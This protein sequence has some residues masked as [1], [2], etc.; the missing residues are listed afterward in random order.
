MTT[1][2]KLDYVPSHKIDGKYA[3]LQ[4]FS[5]DQ[6]ECWLC[7]IRV[8]GN[9][10]NL[11]FLQE[12]LESIEWYAS[13]EW[14]CFDI[15]LDNYVSATTA[16]EMT[17]V[18]LNSQSFHRKF[19][20][21]LKMIDFKFKKK[22]SNTTKMSIVND[23]L[24][25]GGIEKFIDDEDVNPEDLVT[26]SEYSD[27]SDSEEDESSDDEKSENDDESDDDEPEEVKNKKEELKKKIRL[28]P[29]VVP[30]K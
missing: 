1:K 30:K 3:L 8:E 28:P 24:G 23:K 13:E 19:D 16:K 20:G 22:M 17:L 15:D 11:K 2:S 6:S 25:M 26:D 5:S 10:E 29:S 4:E 12:Q 14:S 18:D 27:D 7:F 21:V 9:E